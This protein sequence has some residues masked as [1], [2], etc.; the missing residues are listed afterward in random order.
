M[1]LDARLYQDEDGVWIAEIPAIFGC[2][3]D[4]LTKE[5][6]LA[7]MRDTAALCLSV[8]R[9]LELPLVVETATVEVAA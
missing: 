3:S 7:N 5:D 8:R 1:K 4:G 6:A 9:D 2:G